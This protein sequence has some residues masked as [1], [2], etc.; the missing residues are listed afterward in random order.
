MYFF[1][2]FKYKLLFTLLMGERKLVK[3]GLS[4]FTIALPKEWLVRHNL[5]KGGVVFCE[6]EGDSILLFPKKNVEPKQETELVLS[7]DGVPM[8]SIIRDLVAAYLTNKGFIVIKGKELRSKL[9]EIRKSITQLPGL[10]VVEETGDKLV[11]KDFINIDEIVIKSLIRRID[12][13]IRSIFTD[14]LE[15]VKN[16]DAELAEA[17]RLR[18]KEVNRLTFLVSKGLNYLSTH[19]HEARNHGVIPA[20]FMHVWE[21][22]NDL[23]KVGD[24]LKRMGMTFP[25][26]K[27]PKKDLKNFEE[28]FN[29]TKEFYINTML[30]LY[31]HDLVLGD[32]YAYIREEILDKC[33]ACLTTQYSLKLRR[34]AN[35]LKYVVSNVNDISRLVRYLEFK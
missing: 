7:V 18:D 6:E 2:S 12:N 16:G 28:V 32:K 15:C 21:L 5:G 19:P 8:Q 17:V 25:E 10:E 26:I 34:I 33:D 11:A 23:E 24:E 31:K 22:N 1:E 4:S 9:A 30:A 13:I 20:N 35:R 14:T 27:L 3:S 29:L